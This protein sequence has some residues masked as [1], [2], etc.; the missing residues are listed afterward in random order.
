M[1]KE[2]VSYKRR[3]IIRCCTLFL[4]PLVLLIFRWQTVGVVTALLLSCV[5]AVVTLFAPSSRIS[6]IPFIWRLLVFYAVQL[7]IS[8]GMVWIHDN[9]TLLDALLEN[10]SAHVE[11]GSSEFAVD[12]DVGLG[13]GFLYQPKISVV[14]PCANEGEFMVKTV[15]S[16]N[17]A[18]PDNIL[19]E[20]VVVDDGST[21]P[22]KTLLTEEEQKELKVKWVRHSSFT[23]LINAKS[24]GAGVATGDIIIFLD[25]HVKPAKDWFS[26]IVKQIRTNYK[27]VVVP[28]ITNLDP[29]TWEEHRTSGGMAKCYLTW[30]ADFKWFSDEDK[31]VP[32]MSGGL[33]AMS[34]KWWKETG[35]YDTRMIGWGGENIDQSL[36]IWLCGG[37]IVNAQD[38]YVAHMWRVSSN[39]KTRPRYTVPGGAV[40]T[41]RYRAASAW[42]DEWLEKLETFPAFSGFKTGEMTRPDISNILEIKKGLKCRPFAWFLYRFR[43]LYF[44][45][46]LVP[47]QVFHLKDDISGMCL[48][49]R[50]Q[51][52]VVLSRCSES[53]KGQLWHQGNR[54]GK[55]CCSGFRNWNSDQCLSGNEM[56]TGLGTNVCSTYGEFHD[57]W[58]KLQNNQLKLYSSD[59]RSHREGCIGMQRDR[60]AHVSLENCGAAGFRQNFRVDTHHGGIVEVQSGECLTALGDNFELLPCEIDPKSG[61]VFGEQ[62][63]TLA[64]MS[65]GRFQLKAEEIGEVPLCA[66]SSSGTKLVVY[67]CYN[68]KMRNYNQEWTFSD[69]VSE[70]GSMIK[71]EESKCISV[72][73]GARTTRRVHYK[74]CAT[75][76]GVPKYGQKFTRETIGSEAEFS[77]RDGGW[78]L[79]VDEDHHVVM[80]ACGSSSSQRWRYEDQGL[81]R[82]INTETSLCLQADREGEVAVSSCSA[83]F[84]ADQ[85]WTVEDSGVVKGGVVDEC[86][87]FKPAQ[88]AKLSVVSCPSAKAM[89][90]WS[91]SEPFEPLETRLYREAQTKYPSLLKED[92]LATGA[93]QEGVV[94][95]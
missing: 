39:P 61:K 49:T 37:E 58:I 95:V 27:R 75:T 79:D 78:C 9:T 31:Y 6:R 42:F 1:A 44:D 36:R 40:V 87:D 13:G 25:C 67:T 29:D 3:Q 18:T 59:P 7:Q 23:G 57:Q 19:Q 46:G 34:R 53:S 41:N 65:S 50:G 84:D 90:R 52:D 68:P 70:L 28:S 5:A 51:N 11:G 48:E 14:L 20:V 4:L 91:I 38:S 71:F 62:K 35:G 55:K 24:K 33:L 80:A 63:I 22:L 8:R 2:N 85:R 86:L 94:E 77:L 16:V 82:I 43:A 92:V 32:I 89:L 56:G 66:D 60:G 74:T 93:L 12:D 17:E 21:P 47:R 64:K 10:S 88:T 81:S 83:Q 72:Q 54:D 76:D 73:V 15:K 26:P 30:D 69:T 45:A